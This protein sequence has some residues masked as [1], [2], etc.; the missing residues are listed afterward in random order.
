MLS[1]HCAG[2]WT[3]A[4]D[5]TI[6]QGLQA[7]KTQLPAAPPGLRFGQLMKQRGG[8]AQPFPV[9]A[10]L[11][12]MGKHVRSSAVLTYHEVPAK[13]RPMLSASSAG[14]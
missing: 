11:T 14:P 7:G 13:P 6:V 3:D 5:R 12:E 2:F 1:M 9:L 8:V 4:A 10:A